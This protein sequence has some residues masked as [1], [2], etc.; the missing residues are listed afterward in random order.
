MKSLFLAD[1]NI[2]YRAATSQG[3]LK[4][5]AFYSQPNRSAK[6]IVTQ[7][8]FSILLDEASIS[9]LGFP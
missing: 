4:Q 9:A 5:P 3:Q 6:N 1:S 2:E 7:Y 8:L